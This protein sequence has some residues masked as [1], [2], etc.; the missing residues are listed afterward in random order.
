MKNLFTFLILVL[1]STTTLLAQTIV[2]T[3]P[4]NRNVVLEEF[5]GIHCV[6]CPDGHAVAQGIYDAHPD[7]VVLINIHQ[8]SFAVPSGTEPDFRT[9]WGDAIAGQSGLLGYPAGTVNRHLFPGY[10]QGSGTAQGRSTWN[11]T[12]NQI[13]NLPSY[14]N[15]ELEA[16]IV[17]STRQL[18]V[19]VEVYYTDNSP[20]ESN[21]LNIAILQNNILGPQTGGNAGN[22]YIHKHMLRHFLT[23][24]WGAE[25]TETSAG[26]LYTGTFVYEMPLEYNDVPL[27]LEDL[28]IVG[29]VAES[30]Q[31]VVSG[32]MAEITYVES[33]ER[34]AAIYSTYAPQTLC[35]GELNAQ[36][37]LKNY[38][39]ETLTSL[40][41]VYSVNDEESAQYSWS[42]QLMQNEIELVSLP[43]YA[44]TPLDDNIISIECAMPNG[45]DDQLPQNDLFFNNNQGSQTFPSDVFFGIQ[46]PSNPQDLTWNISNENGEIFAEGGPYTSPGFKV[47]PLTFQNSGCYTL[48]VNDASGSG[49][50]NGQYIIA[51][52]NSNILWAGK[53]FTYKAISEFAYDITIDIPEAS[54]IQTF[55]VYPNPVSDNLN[56]EFNLNQNSNVKLTMT[57]MV[58]KVIYQ[59][60]SKTEAAGLLNYNINTS[61]L[62][63]GM[64]LLLLQV[65]NE[66][67]TQKVTVK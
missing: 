19:Y 7:D 42:G 50:N 22:N 9:Q 28:D 49:L 33:Y 10:S 44:Y 36:V 47:I 53:S 37:M 26:S 18:V 48:T 54:N 57:D 12:S 29:Y 3:D 23:G 41:F 52:L 6:Y 63:S 61:G 13:L 66:T 2:G 46:T 32:N 56:I 43:G 1:F 58:G 51:D 5:T 17:T 11:V 45:Q 64:Y 39:A 40:D 24:Q 38:G 60:N 59:N 8:G 65:G 27:V 15:I 4:E 67:F 55:S 14:L 35:T 34:D 31:E 30:H 62:N 16:I 25:I 21:F 20:V